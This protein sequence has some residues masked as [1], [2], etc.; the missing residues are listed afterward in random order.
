MGTFAFALVPIMV[1]ILIGYG[2]KRSNFLVAQSWA[3]MEKLTYYILFPAL[4]IRTL[5]LS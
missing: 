4:L 1:L 3:G 2:L 5:G